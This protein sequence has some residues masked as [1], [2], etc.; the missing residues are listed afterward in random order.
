MSQIVHIVDD[1][2]VVCASI[3]LL[4][5]TEG[6]EAR[7]YSS[8]AEFLSA[9][10]PDDCGCVV[11]DVRLP[12]MSGVDLL[13][14]IAAQGLN[15][16]VIVITGQADVPLAVH[17]MREGA[18]DFLEKPF[19]E[20][21]L[22]AAVRKALQRS[23]SPEQGAATQEIRARLASLTAR[24]RDVLEGLV[25]GKSNKTIA[26]GLGISFR[27]VEIYRA[28]LMKK[29]QARSLP[30]LVRMAISVQDRPS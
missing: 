18:V 5:E 13:T 14:H 6:I 8:A 12:G 16:P 21:T 23:S 2:P 9:I 20:A 1:D 19:R 3:R 22:I 15:F 24:E 30:E 29:S 11:A 28:N 26:N 4:I 7:T 25:D 10:G 27:T 17:A